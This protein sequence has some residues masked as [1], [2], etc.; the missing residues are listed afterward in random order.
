VAAPGTLRLARLGTQGPLAGTLVARLG[1]VGRRH[2]ATRAHPTARGGLTARVP[3][4]TDS[5]GARLTAARLQPWGTDL[6]ASAGGSGLGR[7]RIQEQSVARWRALGPGAGPAGGDG[8]RLVTLCWA[9]LIRSDSGPA[10]QVVARAG[11]GPERPPGGDCRGW[12]PD[13]RA[14]GSGSCMPERFWEL[15]RMARS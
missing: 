10:G 13:T 12:G 11:L 4:G 14:R 15:T 7:D 1:S 5:D 2:N 3:R 8:D 6:L 9:Y